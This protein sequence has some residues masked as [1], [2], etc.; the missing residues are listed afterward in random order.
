MKC[1]FKAFPGV[2]SLMFL[3]I[4]CSGQP[5]SA[6]G[7]YSMKADGVPRILL[8]SN[9][10][11]HYLLDSAHIYVEAIDQHGNSIWRTDPW[12]DNKLLPYR[13]SRPIVASFAIGTAYWTHG[14]REILITYNNSQTG[15]LDLRTGKFKFVMQL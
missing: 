15:Y 11:I 12:K 2:V 5:D 13:T 14:K 10:G 3:C 4:I 8:D 1:L 6:A 9:T 7:Y